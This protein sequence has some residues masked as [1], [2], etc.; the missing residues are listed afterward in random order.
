[1]KPILIIKVSLSSRY[2]DEFND[3]YHHEYIPDILENIP[4]IVSAR[5]Y[6]EFNT[7][8]TLRYYNKFLLTIYELASE[9]EIKTVQEALKQRKKSSITKKWQHFQAKMSH[10]EAAEI[11][12]CRYEHPRK[13][14]DG[15]FG[16]RPFFSVSI[17][18]QPE[19]VDEFNK[20]YEEEYLPTNLAD[21]PTWVACRRYSCIDKSRHIAIYEAQD[22]AGLRHSLDLMRSK[23][24]LKENESW[25][26]WDT[27]MNPAIT[28]EDATSFTPIFWKEREE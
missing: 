11:Y 8:G 23:S 13:A 17:E 27:G 9:K 18:V 25:L 16:N 26:K 10:H 28:W 19:K 4:Q 24:R 3:F 7:E 5:R 14:L 1:M 20:W 21:V 22:E 2:E 15:P 6:E 12:T